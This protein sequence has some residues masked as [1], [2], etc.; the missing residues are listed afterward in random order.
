[1]IELGSV[2]RKFQDEFIV[3]GLCTQ[4][5]AKL[6]EF[7][8]NEYIDDEK[9]TK[10]IVMEAKSELN[11]ADTKKIISSAGFICE[12]LEPMDLTEP[13]YFEVSILY[14][15]RVNIVSF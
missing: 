11:C 12:F 5:I 15:V 6:R 14:H 2:W 4:I 13:V 3:I 8:L 9:F 1:M 10:M 7:L